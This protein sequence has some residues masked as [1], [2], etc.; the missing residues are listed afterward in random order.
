MFKA[1]KFRP[2]DVTAGQTAPEDWSDNWLSNFMAWS[3]LK[4]LDS[5]CS[6]PEHWT[7]RVMDYFYTDCPCCLFFRGVIVGLG[8]A[9]GVAVIIGWLL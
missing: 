6:T 2:S 9:T 4:Y 7:S 3:S 8:L 5:W 1:F